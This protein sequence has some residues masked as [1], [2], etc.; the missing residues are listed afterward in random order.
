MS[1]TATPESQSGSQPG[2]V[3]FKLPKE[4]RLQIYNAMLPPGKIYLCSIRDHL[5]LARSPPHPSEDDF[6]SDLSADDSNDDPD[7]YSPRLAAR[8][9]IAM[10]A[11]CRAIH[12]EGKPIIYENT[13]FKIHC[14][15]E[16]R[17]RCFLIHMKPRHARDSNDIWRSWRDCSPETDVF[18]H[19]QHARSIS[20][21][22]Y[23]DPHT[24]SVDPWLQQ[25]PAEISAAP[26]LRKL[27]ISFQ[28]AMNAVYSA[29]FQTQADYT[30]ALFGSIKCKCPVTVA[31]ETSIGHLGVKGFKTA[32][33]FDM[34]DALK[35]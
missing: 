12:E 25:M 8:D 28:C 17:T 23:L 15:G 10:L 18:H 21:N 6:G 31:M 29:E 26:N 3:L 9:Y 2:G 13:H 19:L 34:L 11:T 32:S 5:K 35:G 16:A 27:H 14:S 4:L 24:M 22:V 7:D 33:Y 20:F 1:S 30:M